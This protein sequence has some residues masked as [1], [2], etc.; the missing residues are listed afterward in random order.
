MTLVER[1]ITNIRNTEVGKL[2]ISKQFFHYTWIGIFIS[3]L[4][5]ALLWLLIDVMF[6]PTVIAGIL[7]V[8]ITFII[9]YLLFRKFEAI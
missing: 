5:V 1:L 3:T 9:R 7:V 6:I 4:N 8:A 2:F